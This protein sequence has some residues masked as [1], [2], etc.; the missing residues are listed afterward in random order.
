M[1]KT[2]EL[3]DTT[4]REGVQG[5]GIEFSL[6]GRLKL[7]GTLDGF[8]VEYVEGGFA[9]ANR[10]EDEFFAEARKV[11]LK[12]AKLVAFGATRR[13]GTRAGRDKGL[14]A[15]AESGAGVAAVFGKSWGLH[16]D[17]VLRTTR[18][19]NLAMILESV[20]FLKRA[21]LEVFFDAEHYFDGLAADLEYAL[22][23]VGAALDGGADR[24]VLCDTNGGRLPEEIA[25][26]V[27]AAAER[28]GAG[29]WG[30]HTHNDCG[31]A[32]ANALAGV[33]AGAGLAQATVNG[34]GE[35]AGNADLCS[36]APC[37]ALKAGY[38]TGCGKNLARLTELSR[39]VDE[40]ADRRP[41][42]RRPFTG[43]DAFAH[44]AGM[45]ADAV[46][47]N[48]ATFEH[49]AP[50][51][52]GNR[53]RLLLSEL[54][55]GAAVRLK[56]GAVGEPLKRG[57]RE[58]AGVK[59][60]L[61]R[62]EKEGYA[63]EAADASFRLLV[64]KILKKYAPH[65]ELKGFSLAVEKRDRTSKATSVATIKVEVGGKEELTAGEGNGPVDALNAALR[66]AL[67]R[68]YPVIDDVA[69][70]DYHV[71][72]LDPETGT[73]ATTRVVIESTDG[74]ERWGTV[75]VSEN[76]I[77]ASWEA[78]SDSMEYKLMRAEE[79][80]GGPDKGRGTTDA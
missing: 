79:E 9:G 10:R 25:A 61:E 14:R 6:P 40:L 13:P 80:A 65:F 51:A 68:F 11:R 63:F 34:Y 46:G 74:K 24:V 39:L 62:L 48:P 41:D 43:E 55:G 20:K 1:K 77:E 29:R 17:E 47:K 67:R 76:V 7:L 22:A 73:R 58:L 4:L 5:A 64:R 3:Y 54:G 44:K 42:G 21:G 60:R 32:T 31:L 37:L 45:H 52:V 18:E 78:L 50:E 53:R 19:E 30:I 69:L 16:V 33:A 66:K 23:C 59:A 15:L 49:I 57:T 35:R 71:R 72:I 38:A 2:V 36:L 70:E 56:S 26:G 75:G 27:R 12:R 28:F 8:G